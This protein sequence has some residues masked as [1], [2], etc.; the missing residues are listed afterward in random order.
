M[1]WGGIFRMR[2]KVALA[3]KSF[4]HDTG[5]NGAPP[6]G[7]LLS[8]PFRLRFPGGCRFRFILLAS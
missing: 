7:V 4:S 8:A 3:P 2:A 1:G 6:L 5:G